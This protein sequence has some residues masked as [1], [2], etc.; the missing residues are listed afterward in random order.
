MEEVTAL[1][2]LPDLK[3]STGTRTCNLGLGA[4][5]L[6]ARWFR[7]RDTQIAKIELDIFWKS[8]WIALSKSPYS[9]ES[10]S[11][12]QDFRSIHIH[13]HSIHLG[14]HNLRLVLDAYAIAHLIATF[15]IPVEERPNLI[16]YVLS[17]TDIAAAVPMN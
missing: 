12:V 17:T 2:S 7:S 9:G 3:K 8:R 5:I 11:D 1:E 14:V 4:I 13:V 6:H 16:A 15:Q 10:W